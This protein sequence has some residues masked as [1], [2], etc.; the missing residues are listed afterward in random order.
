MR[1]SLVLAVWLSWVL[2]F[3]DSVMLFRRPSVGARVQLLETEES[4]VEHAEE[5]WLGGA[6]VAIDLDPAPPCFAIV[7]PA[8]PCFAIVPGI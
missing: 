2:A 3:V 8:P 7:V 5:G 4:A 6:S 1:I